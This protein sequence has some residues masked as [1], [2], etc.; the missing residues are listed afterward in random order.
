MRDLFF[1]SDTSEETL[2]GVFY[3]TRPNYVN[4]GGITFKYKQLDP[5][6]RVFDKVLSEIRA[7]S[8]RY[9]IKTNDACGF[10]IGGYIVTQNGEFWEITEVVTN[11]EER[12]T[13]NALRW[14]KRVS[15]SEIS[16]RMIKISDLYTL[17]S[18]Y[19][20]TCKVVIALYQNGVEKTVSSASTSNGIIRV[21]GTNE[22]T[23]TIEKGESAI[24]RL[25]YAGGSKTVN[26]KRFNT[27]RQ[28]NYMEINV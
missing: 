26:V 20:T 9:A 23:L 11:E 4:D 19:L 27:Q 1:L 8:A 22:A 6:S 18:A 15:N 21:S 24:V 2:T 12:T 17:E 25:I 3:K 10:N 13:K 16:V 5:N 28:D 7:D 14:F